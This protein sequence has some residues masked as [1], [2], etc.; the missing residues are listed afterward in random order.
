MAEE[1]KAVIKPGDILIGLLPP[2]EA[3]FLPQK[4]RR[5]RPIVLLAPPEFD[6]GAGWVV[7]TVAHTT[8]RNPKKDEIKGTFVHI[9]PFRDPATLQGH[10]G[11]QQYVDV[12]KIFQIHARPEHVN[13]RIDQEGRMVFLVVDSIGMKG[14]EAILKKQQELEYPTKIEP[15][16]FYRLFERLRPRFRKITPIEP[17]GS[18]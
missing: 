9:T 5:Q 14:A 10:N 6:S 8:L 18:N 7:L 12:E 2:E 4:R 16:W 17:P 11:R 1:Y 15:I 13:C 3:P